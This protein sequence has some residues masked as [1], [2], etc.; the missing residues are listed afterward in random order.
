MTGVHYGLDH[1]G[2]VCFKSF[3]DGRFERFEVPYA[4]G[5]HSEVMIRR[6]A[7]FL[8]IEF[9]PVVFKALALLFYLDQAKPPVVEYDDGQGEPHPFRRD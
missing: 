4:N 9:R 1:G 3:S 8:L 7:V 6:F 2:A 5:G